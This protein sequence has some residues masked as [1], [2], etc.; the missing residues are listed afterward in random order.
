MIVGL[1]S[2]PVLAVEDTITERPACSGFIAKHNE[3]VI[4]AVGK[5]DDRQPPYSTF[6]VALALMGFD[7][8]ILENKESPKWAFKA[9]YEKN[10]QNWYTREKG[11]KYHWCQDHTPATFMRYSVVWFSHQIT[12]R[13]GLERF[14][15]Y[16]VR[17]N[18]GN[19]DVRGTLGKNDGLYNSWLGTSLQISPREQVELLENLR[20]NKLD[21]S[22][23]AQAKTRE[24]MDRGEEWNGWKL[25]G[26]TG[27]GS[28]AI[29]WFVG[30][31]EKNGQQ[32][33]FAQYLDLNDPNLNL[34]GIPSNLPVG[35]TAKEMIK[36]EL[37]SFLE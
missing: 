36:R 22:K 5:Y 33:V 26:K 11:L 35:L 30:W 27:G 1:A 23:E 32:I 13:L 12:Q 16:I 17:L 10:F 18:Y 20:A 25:Y 8:G 15:D 19:Q 7:A 21:I 6:K 29:G 28:D 34:E 9:E 2:A 3:A 14:Q 37:L 4:K 24:V 31:I